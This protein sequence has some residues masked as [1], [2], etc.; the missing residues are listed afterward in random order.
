MNRALAR[1][2]RLFF[3]AVALGLIAIVE[4]DRVRRRALNALAEPTNH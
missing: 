4:L 3:D 1:L 2:Q